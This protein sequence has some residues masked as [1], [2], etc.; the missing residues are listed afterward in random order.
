MDREEKKQVVRRQQATP[1]TIVTKDIEIRLPVKDTPRCERLVEEKKYNPTK[2]YD[3]NLIDWVIC[4]TQDLV[5]RIAN[6][7]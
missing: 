3:G 5:K 2:T 6:F 7:F 1:A 4:G